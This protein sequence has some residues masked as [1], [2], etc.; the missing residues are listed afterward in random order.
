MDATLKEIINTINGSLPPAPG[1]PV[2]VSILFVGPGAK[3]L[4]EKLS[5]TDS[6]GAQGQQPNFPF[7]L[8]D[9]LRYGDAQTMLHIVKEINF[10]ENNCSDFFSGPVYIRKSDAELMRLSNHP[11]PTTL[12]P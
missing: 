6:T 3:L 5:D 4:Y 10:P 9:N 12:K 1:S 2:P 11:N 8:G 7:I